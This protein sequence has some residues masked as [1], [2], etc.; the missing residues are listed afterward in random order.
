M[1]LKK[2]F[3]VTLASVG[4][5]A[6]LIGGGT[7]ALFTSEA[8]NTGNTF[9]AGS[10]EVSLDKPDGTTYFNVENIAPG[11]SET[12]TVTVKNSGTLEL[13][14]DLGVDLTGDLAAAP[15][16]LTVKV[17]DKNGNEIAPG[18]DGNRVLAAGASEEL[19]VTY[20]LPKEAGNEYQGKAA[21]LGLKVLAEQTKNN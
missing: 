7:F 9:A 1:S 20:T 11:D 19:K 4:L 2:Q 13:R 14:Y 12:K 21:T 6:A 15:N 8:Q 17:T 3:A 10:V 5:G 18:P 16:G